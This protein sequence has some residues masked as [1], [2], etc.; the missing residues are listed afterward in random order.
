LKSNI[1]DKQGV[2]MQVCTRDVIVRQI[3][4]ARLARPLEGRAMWSVQTYANVI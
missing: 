2:F 3:G 4:V 1:F